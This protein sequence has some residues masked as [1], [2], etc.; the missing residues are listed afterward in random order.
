MKKNNRKFKIKVSQNW[1]NGVIEVISKT[2]LGEIVSRY[3]LNKPLKDYISAEELKNDIIKYLEDNDFTLSYQNLE[4]IKKRNQGALILLGEEIF[5]DFT[6]IVERDDTSELLRN[7]PVFID[8]G[9]TIYIVCHVDVYDRCHN[10][11]IFNNKKE[12]KMYKD[13]YQNN[14]NCSLTLKIRKIKNPN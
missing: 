3:Y 8:K 4:L 11:V 9:K 2:D 5:E 1:R 14:D 10:K 12:V 7:R 13:K 6:E